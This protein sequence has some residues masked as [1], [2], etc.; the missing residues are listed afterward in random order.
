MKTLVVVGHPDLKNSRVNKAW[1]E[2]A[3]A[4]PDEEVFVHTLYDAAVLCDGGF[5]IAEEQKLLMTADRVVLQYPLW[6]YMPPAIMKR[7][8][9]T[10]WAEGFGWGEGGDKMKHLRIDVA[11]SCG[12]PE[13]A[14]SRTSLP[15][16]L[17]Y[18]QGSIDFI[19]AR[20]GE[21]FCLYD[22]DNVGQNRP[23]DLA[24]SC[25]DYTAFLKGT[26]KGIQL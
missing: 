17:S 25:E 7:W 6:W 19:Q 12:A 14:F 26:L 8:M 23:E 1:R 15:A 20:R 5:D 13:V 21:I 11:V 18:I 3:I 24:K 2:A 10:V 16:Y 22:A 4:L 9:D